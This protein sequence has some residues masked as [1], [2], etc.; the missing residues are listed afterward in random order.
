MKLKLSE[1]AFKYLFVSDDHFREQ[2]L[3]FPE[4]LQ[5]ANPT[6]VRQREREYSGYQGVLGSVLR[7]EKHFIGCLNSLEVLSFYVVI[8]L[9]NVPVL[10]EELFFT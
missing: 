2:G 4:P 1:D 6:F 5:T 3:R 8:G 9:L 7:V 10:S